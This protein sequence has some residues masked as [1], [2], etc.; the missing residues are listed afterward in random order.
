MWSFVAGRNRA[1]IIVVSNKNR[2]K[3]IIVNH[4]T[5]TEIVEDS[6]DNKTT[7]DDNKDNISDAES[8]VKSNTDETKSLVLMI[9]DIEYAVYWLD[10]D[11]VSH[12][13]DLVIN[14]LKWIIIMRLDKLVNLAQ[15]SHQMIHSSM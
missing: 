3:K 4:S 12:L 15:L 14:E 7:I 13:R 9:D 8:D 10:N 6:I 1:T 5:D 2:D 11:S